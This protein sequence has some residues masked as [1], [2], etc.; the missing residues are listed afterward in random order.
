VHRRIVTVG[1]D[2]LPC[3]PVKNAEASRLQLSFSIQDEQGRSHRP[4]VRVGYISEMPAWPNAFR[5]SSVCQQVKEKDPEKLDILMHGAAGWPS[6]AQ[7]ATL[8]CLCL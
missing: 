2:L 3:P 7:G 5:G 8:G 4:Q 6:T 1:R